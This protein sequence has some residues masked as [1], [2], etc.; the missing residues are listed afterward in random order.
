MCRQSKLITKLLLI[1]T[2]TLNVTVDKLYTYVPPANAMCKQ[3]FYLYP[4]QFQENINM[5][6][7]MKLK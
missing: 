4:A 3:T 2:V 6:K 5:G 7:V 1:T